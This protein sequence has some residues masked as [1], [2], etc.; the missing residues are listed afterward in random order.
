MA[1]YVL[2]PALLSA[3]KASRHVECKQTVFLRPVLEGN[4]SGNIL[5]GHAPH[6]EVSVNDGPHIRRWS[7]NIKKVKQSHYRPGQALRVSTKLR[8]PDFKT[9]G[10]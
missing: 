8:L 7:Q 6:K 9:I 1:V 3:C 5:Y 4:K 2:P 10:T